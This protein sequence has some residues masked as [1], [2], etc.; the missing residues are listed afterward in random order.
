MDSEKVAL[1]AGEFLG[2]IRAFRQLLTQRITQD[3]EQLSSL[4]E[5]VK[6]LDKNFTEFLL[7]EAKREGE[8]TGIKR[9]VVYLAG[10][11]SFIISLTG[12]IL[13]K[14]H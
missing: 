5:S 2:E 9:S 3:T 7:R 1:L 6:Q 8:A 12:F 13:N 10:T 11:I 4:A 14:I